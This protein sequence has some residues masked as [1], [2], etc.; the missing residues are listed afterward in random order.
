MMMRESRERIILELFLAV[1][2]LMRSGKKVYR[3]L[4]ATIKLIWT[5]VAAVVSESVPILGL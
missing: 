2:C 4:S 1:C 3:C 5:S